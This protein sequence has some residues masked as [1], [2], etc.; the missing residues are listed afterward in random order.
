MGL[1]PGALVLMCGLGC[2]LSAVCGAVRWAG[3]EVDSS[4]CSSA[5][6]VVDAPRWTVRAVVR[7]ARVEGIAAAC[8]LPRSLQDRTPDQPTGESVG[9]LSLIHI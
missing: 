1:T 5:C 8:S 6:A 4:C 7:A 2:A 9:S 3:V